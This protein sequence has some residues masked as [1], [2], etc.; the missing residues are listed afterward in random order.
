[1][2]MYQFK[3]GNEPDFIELKLTEVIDFPHTTDFEGGYVVKGKVSIQSGRY[4]V[5][6]AEVWFTTGQ[7]Y[8]LYVQLQKLYEQLKGSIHFSNRGETLNFTLQFN[9]Y[10]QIQ[11][12]GYFQ[13]LLSEENQ[14]QFGFQLDQ[15]YLPKTLNELKHIVDLYGDMEGINVN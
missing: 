15:S 6:D 13:E 10:G 12:R 4:F 5:K 3:L 14:L 11:V 9:R 1:M 8:E 2:K 7:V